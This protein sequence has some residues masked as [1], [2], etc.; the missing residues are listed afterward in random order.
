MVP[1]QSKESRKQLASAA[2]KKPSVSNLEIEHE[3]ASAAI[4]FRVQAIWKGQ[5]EEDMREAWKREVWE[6]SDQSKP[7]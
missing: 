1:T 6:G 7:F 5:L 2:R 4:C 3:F